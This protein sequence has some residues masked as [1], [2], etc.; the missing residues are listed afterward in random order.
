MGGN[1]T[2]SPAHSR[3]PNEPNPYLRSKTPGM[4]GSHPSAASNQPGS[5]FDAMRQNSIDSGRYGILRP[6][7]QKDIP[8][9]RAPGKW[10]EFVADPNGVSSATQSRLNAKFMFRKPGTGSGPNL[11]RNT[12]GHRVKNDP[13][14]GKD[15]HQFVD[16]VQ[17]WHVQRQSYKDTAKRIQNRQATPPPPV[18][19]PLPGPNA[20]P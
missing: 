14:T 20:T 19:P 10:S 8:N 13:Y 17:A 11:V 4:H 5:V 15:M 16:P 3:N 18:H 1:A 2:F 7:Q 6:A 12:T 9:V